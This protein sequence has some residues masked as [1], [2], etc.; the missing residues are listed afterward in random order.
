MATKLNLRNPNGY[1]GSPGTVHKQGIVRFATLA[2]AAAGIMNDVAITPATANAAT[3]LDFASPPVLGFGSTT[4]RPVNSTTLNSTGLTNLATVAGSVANIGNATGSL[5]F[6]G[7]TAVVKPTSTTDL[8][9]ALI[10]LGLY[11]T[12]GASPLNLNGGAFSAGTVTSASNITATNGN[13]VFGTAG[14][15]IISTSVG[16]TATAGANSFGSATLVSGTVT[17]ATTAVTAN[18]LIKLSRQSIGS[19]GANPLGMLTVGTITAGTSFIINAATT[20]SATTTVTTDV[21]VVNWEIV[22]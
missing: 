13:L 10:N 19:T 6:F 20:A 22:N 2:E 11:T 18:S 12:G 8:R 3:A 17:I 7:A 15:K 16:T 5:G 14:N 21:S 9:T 4:P 1:D